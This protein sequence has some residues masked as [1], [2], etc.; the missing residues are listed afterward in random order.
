MLR[1]W[2]LV[3]F[4]CALAAMGGCFTTGQ[5]QPDEPDRPK[6]PDA[7]PIEVVHAFYAHSSNVLYKIDPLTNELTEVGPFSGAFNPAADQATDLA[8]NAAGELYIATFSKIM[9]VNPE[10]A[11]AEL[12]SPQLSFSANALTFM[13]VDVGN[14]TGAE[15][16]IA[17][18]SNQLAEINQTTGEATSVGS[19][20]PSTGFSGDL[21][22]VR[23]VGIYAMLDAGQSSTSLARLD[24]TTFEATLIG[25]T[26]FNGVWGMAF[27]A[28][29]FYGFS[30][31]GEMFTIDVNTGVGTLVVGP[32]PNVSFWGA[33]VS[34]T[35][36]SE[37]IS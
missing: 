32:L 20:G 8:L 13:P 27:Y 37:P 3:A 9:R 6:N 25:P 35:A 21:F 19:L 26:G 17:G 23:D 1:S 28:G 15:R 34:T 4:L 31:A 36:P 14:P 33:G 5:S 30:A 16:L 24:E 18:G 29:T 10:T 11:E 2:I 12:L 7:P 22:Y